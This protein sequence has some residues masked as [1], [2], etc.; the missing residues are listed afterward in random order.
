MEILPAQKTCCKCGV[1]K[2]KSAF[3]RSNRWKDGLDCYCKD[4]KNE[5]SFKSRSL[6]K[7]AGQCY[8]CDSPSKP[9]R[10][11]CHACLVR[12]K[13]L[14][15]VMRDARSA[16][17]LCRNCGA[18]PA[19]GKKCDRCWFRVMAGQHLGDPDMDVE[20]KALWH[21]QGGLCAL[22]RIKLIPCRNASL[23]HIVPV[24][25]GGKSV[26]ANLRWTATRVNRARDNMTD[27]EF[28]EMCR[29]VVETSSRKKKAAHAP[30]MQLHVQLSLIR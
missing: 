24:S 14:S 6:R 1:T 7:A 13:S 19:N 25:R 9:G 3:Y 26:I 5:P 18:K 30:K 10:T 4:C 2:D 22:S 16:S 17:G 12:M 28:V 29:A 11:R 8:T 23:D 27:A 20:L 15:K 21:K